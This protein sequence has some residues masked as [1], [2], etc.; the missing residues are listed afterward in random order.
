[1]GATSFG[2]N[3][4]SFHEHPSKDND[5]INSKVEPVLP[6]IVEESES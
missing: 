3:E 1:M 5:N 4:R 2:G 6:E